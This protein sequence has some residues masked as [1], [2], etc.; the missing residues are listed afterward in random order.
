M[1]VKTGERKH[2]I[3]QMLAE[4]LEQPRAARITSAELAALRPKRVANNADAAY[5][6]TTQIN[7]RCGRA[8]PLKETRS[9]LLSRGANATCGIALN[10]H[11][12]PLHIKGVKDQEATF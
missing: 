12:V 2:Q 8:S 1:S 7:S 4:M 3:L 11:A 5:G 10:L 6:H 9:D